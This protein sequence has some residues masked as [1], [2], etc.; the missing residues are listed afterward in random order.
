MPQYLTNR[1]HPRSPRRGSMLLEAVVS[2]G[3]LGTLFVTI[4]Q[5]VVLLHRQTGLADRHF[6][7]QQT[8]ENPLEQFTH[9]PWSEITSAQ[10]D[11]LELPPLALSKL[12][13]AVLRGEVTDESEPVPAKR[14]TL[15][16]GWRNGP[17]GASRPLI[18]TAWIYPRPE[19]QP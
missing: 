16:L 14:I 15:R 1:R 4:G 17:E 10:V 5:V 7:A 11:Q 3:L 18:L 9:R 6:V 8:L 2:A 13:R 12:P 19:E